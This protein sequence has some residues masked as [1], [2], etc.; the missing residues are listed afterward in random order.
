MLGSQGL[1]NGN[2]KKLGCGG[3]GGGGQDFTANAGQRDSADI[4]S[5]GGGSDRPPVGGGFS[6]GTGGSNANN[7]SKSGNNANRTGNGGGSDLGPNKAMSDMEKASNGGNDAVN[8]SSGGNGFNG[9]GQG[10][11]GS[12]GGNTV[13]NGFSGGSDLGPSRPMSN[14]SSSNVGQGASNSFNNKSGANGG[15]SDPYWSTLHDNPTPSSNAGGNGSFVSNG[16]SGGSSDP[17]INA[18]PTGTA[19]DMEMAAGGSHPM[20]SGGSSMPSTSIGGSGFSGSSGGTSG[21]SRGG[22]G[23]NSSSSSGGSGRSN[24]NGGNSGGSNGGGQQAQPMAQNTAGDMLRAARYNNQGDVNS[25]LKVAP[26]AEEHMKNI[27]DA[28][29]KRVSS[30]KSFVNK[31]IPRK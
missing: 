24:G 20:P 25:G 16:G 12:S 29:G 17:L 3:D 6:G 23:S 2:A 5:S 21:G 18:D 9:A 19:S 15:S 11:N 30:A 4:A 22:G 26:T 27:E 28:I 31:Y 14:M 8:G 1:M 10:S 13:A 7:T